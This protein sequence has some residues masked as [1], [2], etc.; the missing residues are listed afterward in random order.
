[1]RRSRLATLRKVALVLSFPAAGAL[2][3]TACEPDLDSLS[4]RYDSSMGGD[5]GLAGASSGSGGKASSGGSG[6]ATAPASCFNDRRNADE[7]DVDCGGPSKCRRCDLNEVCTVDSDCAVDNCRAN[8]CTEPTCTDNKK[9]GNETDEDCGGSCA[10]ANRCADGQQCELDRDCESGFCKDG[11]CTS[12]CLSGKK[13]GDETDRDC[14][15]SCEP[16]AN[17]KACKGNGDC[18]SEICENKVC[19]GPSCVDSLLNQA[20][21]DVDCGGTC[22]ADLS[23]IEAHRCELDQACK[24]NNDCD[25]YSCVEQKCVAAV[26]YDPVNVIDTFDDSTNA[27]PG[28]AGRRGSWYPFGDTS[29][30]NQSFSI[31]FIPGGRGSANVYAAHTTG[32]GYTQWGAGIGVDFNAVGQAKYPYDASAYSGVTFW[33]RTATSDTTGRALKVLFPDGNSVY[34]SAGGLTHCQDIPTVGATSNNCDKNLY[35]TVTLAPEWKKFTVNFATDL[36]SD[37]GYTTELALDQLVSIQFR[38]ATGATFDYW[39]DDIVFIPAPTP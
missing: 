3:I 19:A 35:A 1:M 16:C 8:R 17:G 9:N 30:S 4:A 22:S 34:N 12:H 15:G 23:S 5:T 36:E 18:D 6:G 37:G 24:V 32:S 7:S 33:A 2:G 21:T 10:P 31:E 27:L 11:E 29:S 20:E 13:D 14:G 25:S 28:N 26:A 39:I 38:T